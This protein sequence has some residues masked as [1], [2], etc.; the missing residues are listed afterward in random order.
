MRTV[1]EVGRALPTQHSHSHL[2]SQLHEDDAP[3]QCPLQVVGG[4][5]SAGALKKGKGDV[6]GA[7][8]P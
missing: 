4:D 6:M 3:G 1:R 2:E 5:W 8:Q 7:H